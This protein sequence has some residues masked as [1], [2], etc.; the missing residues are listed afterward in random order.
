MLI[1]REVL[2][3]AGLLDPKYFYYFED[4]DYCFRA[5]KAGYLCLYVPSPSCRHKTQAEWITNS[6]QAYYYMRNASMFARINLDGFRKYIFILSQAFI[7]F[8]YFSVKLGI[9][10]P[11]VLKGLARGLKDGL[12]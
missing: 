4:T 1:K 5:K 10:N 8:P 6:I 3:K 7:M 12:F 11:K 2:N 9:R